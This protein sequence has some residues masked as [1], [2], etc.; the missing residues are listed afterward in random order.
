MRDCDLDVWR[1]EARRVEARRRHDL[2]RAIRASL[3]ECERGKCDHESCDHELGLRPLSLAAVALGLE[4]YLTEE[5]LRAVRE[6]EPVPAAEPVVAKTQAERRSEAARKA[7]K[8]SPWRGRAVL[9]ARGHGGG[10]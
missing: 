1:T 10:R 4:R 3:E 9:P 5:E 2:L 8:S 6:P 7:S